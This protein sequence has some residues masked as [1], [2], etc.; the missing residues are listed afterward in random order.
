MLNETFKL[1]DTELTLIKRNI[2]FLSYL[3][4]CN[5]RARSVT[6]TKNDKFLHIKVYWLQNLTLLYLD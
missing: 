2:C 6:E 5:L 4:I 1:R 3:V